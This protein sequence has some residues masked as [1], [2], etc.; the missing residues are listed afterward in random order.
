M[1]Q[2]LLPVFFKAYVSRSGRIYPQKNTLNIAR[3]LL[4]P[5]ADPHYSFGDANFYRDFLIKHPACGFDYHGDKEADDDDYNSLWQDFLSALTNFQNEILKNQPQDLD[6]DNNYLLTDYILL[7][8]NEDTGYTGHGPKYILDL[9]DDILHTRQTLPLFES[10]CAQEPHALRESV[11]TAVTIDLRHAHANRKYALNEAQRDALAHFLTLKNGEMLAVNGPPG[12]GKTSLV[13]DVIASLWTQSAVNKDPTPPVI[14]AASTNNQA[15][16]NI[17][18]AFAN[19][20]ESDA[21]GINRRWIPE[22]NTFGSYY[23]A[24]SKLQENAAKYVT[25]E[26]FMR[27]VETFDFVCAAKKYFLREASRAFKRDLAS[28]SEALELIHAALIDKISAVR[29]LL[30][31]RATMQSLLQQSGCGSVTDL[32]IKII[33]LKENK[34]QRESIYQHWERLDTK[35]L[36]YLSEHSSILKSALSVIPAYKRSVADNARLH[37]KA[38]WDFGDP[39][40]EVTDEQSISAFLHEK[41]QTHK[42]DL[43]QS[44]DEL[45][46]AE[47]LLTSLKEHQGKWLDWCREFKLSRPDLSLKELDAELDIKA[48]FYTF[49]LAVH[50]WEARWLIAMN[51]GIGAVEKLNRTRAYPSAFDLR[52]RWQLRA[53]LTPCVVSTFYVLPWHL[54]CAVRSGGTDDKYLYNFLDLLI[55]DEAGQ[56]LPEVAGASFALSKKALVFGDVFQLEPIWSVSEEIDRNNLRNAGLLSDN[57]DDEAFKDLQSTGK[58]VSSGSVMLIAQQSSPYHYNKE[59]SRGMFLYEHRRCYDEIIDFCNAL[60]YHDHL[61]PKRG[62]AP[63]DVIFPPLGYVH[64]S[65]QCMKDR[66]GSR[67]NLEEARTI[68]SWIKEYKDKLTA[69]YHAPI[70]NIVAILSPF[71][72]QIKNIRKALQEQCPEVKT[73]YKDENSMIIGTVHSLQGAERPIV[74]FSPVYTKFDSGNF[75]DD[76][77]NMLNVAVSRAKDSFIVFGDMDAFDSGDRLKPRGVLARFLYQKAANEIIFTTVARQQYRANNET[78]CVLRDYASH[79]NFLMQ[80]VREARTDLRIV[81]PWIRKKPLADLQIL[82]L[83]ARSADHGI[84]IR[85]YTDY[86][87]NLNQD[88]SSGAELQELLDE[89]TELNVELIFVKNVHS[90][91]VLADD[92]LLCIGSFNWLSARAG[93]PFARY[94]T[95]IVYK[96]AKQSALFKEIKELQKDIEK[97]EARFNAEN[98]NDLT[99][100]HYFRVRKNF[101][102]SR[103][104]AGA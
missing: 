69:H 101:N 68:A 9:Y 91:M 47:D 79:R 5:F 77:P 65:G 95:S 15:V 34:E 35:W 62:K 25:Y 60:V 23:P 92:R 18:D 57:A 40:P 3:D 78:V 90:K 21:D 64:V 48:R 54:Q 102:Q 38:I 70:E 76:K 51:T 82:P 100:R 4:N 75:I 46:S 41:V 86:A 98:G 27:K 30:D 32:E 63:D 85:I 19:N 1:P 94:E 52:R 29:R 49:Y 39:L 88:R 13:L 24:F 104:A 33:K 22:I 87:L 44:A 6:I 16:T 99:L 97:R 71:G 8:I 14:A 74:I 42:Q 93:G 11:A 67:F 81:S 58:T 55:V 50:Y 31:T 96:T 37:F 80:T 17:I 36:T 45:K 83:I 26:Y 61:Q 73:A 103:D 59:L 2:T 66:G 20:F 10:Y 12:T 53:M 89:L 7:G 43:Q 72:A 28:V 84:K 56:V